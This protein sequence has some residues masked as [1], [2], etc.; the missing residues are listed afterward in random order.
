MTKSYADALFLDGGTAAPAA[1]TPVARDYATDLVGGTQTDASPVADKDLKYDYDRTLGFGQQV[2]GS[3][4][5]DDKE[6][7]RHA[8]KSLYPGEPLQKSIQRF[9]KTKEGRYFH[10]GDDGKMYEVQPP[11]GVGRLAN[12]GGGVGHAIPVGTATAT[13]IAT[14][15]MAATGVGL[16]GTMGATAAAG[17]GGEVIRQKI[18]DY[19]LGDAADNE[20]SVPKVLYEGAQSG[21]GQGVGAGFGAWLARSAAP[22]I[23]RYS[24]PAANR[25]LDAADRAGVRVTPAEATGLESLVAEQKRLMGVP[26]SA[27]V[28]KDFMRERNQEV[29]D[30]YRGFLNRLASPQDASRLA[31]DG[32]DVADN[33]Y[34]TAQRART[35]A[36]E[37]FYTAAERE[38]GFVSPR[39]AQEYIAQE[40]PTAKGAIRRALE[41][42]QTAL[43][44]TGENASDA[45]FRGLDNAKKAIDA[46]MRN[47]DLAARE[48]ID[49]SA[50]R[51]LSE[52]RDRLV[53]AIDAA[54]GNS[55][56]YQQGRQAYAG[57]TE[58]VV[59]P[60]RQA[61][62]PLLNINRGRSIPGGSTN[63]TGVAQALL[64]PARRSPEQIR[65]ARTL[66]ERQD[67]D[68]WNRF[69]RQFMQEETTN[70]LR[71]MASGEMR[72]VGGGISK[73]LGSEP[74]I[75][76]LR[77]A[78][79]PRQFREF[80]DIMD[81]FRATARAMDTNSDTAFKQEMIR[82][83]K[84]RAGGGVARLIRNLN[85]AKMAENAAD[86]FAERNYERQAEAI[87]NIIT[88][89]DRQAI[90][91][92]R[93]LRQLEPGDWR[94]YAVMGEVLTRTGALATESALD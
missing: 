79:N 26:Q 85:P 73:A 70:V 75:E 51:A 2:V 42:A 83:A 48:G 22:D 91:R 57:M 74:M 29:Y 20:L 17:A 9:G 1:V 25:L 35:T 45:S 89:G 7:M 59:N 4:A 71:T 36:V 88:S 8:A 86:F 30:A 55:G 33:L 34:A 12:I 40:M 24:A 19:L 43:Q 53:T 64:D 82:R 37:P 46:L 68:L 65:A 6:W 77:A 11:S 15:P 54:A 66:I 10:K 41:V 69:V 62:D 63:L 38:I 3:F 72:N 49:R 80:S 5:S 44:R 50:H 27:N 93:A 28:M 78:M 23:G 58:N 31:R 18:G 60:A 81:V 84:N 32:A 61:L 14:A 92:I 56:A 87:A 16:L 52:V 13:G 21:L 67:P 90:N 76:N 47:P 39:A 94:R